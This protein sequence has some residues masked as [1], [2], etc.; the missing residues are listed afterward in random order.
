MF[1]HSNTVLSKHI[2]NELEKYQK[3]NNL[4]AIT[5]PNVPEN[6]RLF[7]P[8]MLPSTFINQV[9]AAKNIFQA[10]QCI[11]FLGGSSVRNA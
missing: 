5:L 2:L 6:S 4:S 8:E 10:L 9:E 1:F 11:S 7:L 3:L